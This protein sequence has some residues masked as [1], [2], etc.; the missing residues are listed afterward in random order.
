[1]WSSGIHSILITMKNVE[2]F[3]PIK[4][5]GNLIALTLSD[6]NS[7][8]KVSNLLNY[9]RVIMTPREVIDPIA[10]RNSAFEYANQAIKDCKMPENIKSALKVGIKRE[11]GFEL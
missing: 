10:Q 2:S 3:G 6:R 7:W 1:V 9:T 5:Y 8:R 4:F 11:F